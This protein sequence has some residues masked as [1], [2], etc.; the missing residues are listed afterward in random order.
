MRCLFA[1]PRIE[2]LHSDIGEDLIMQAAVKYHSEVKTVPFG[3]KMI[4]YESLTPI[5]TPKERERRKREIEKLLF[6]VFV[7]YA[8]E[9]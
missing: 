7:K 8:K 6:D 5:L 9:A 2:N 3:G 1:C 4:T